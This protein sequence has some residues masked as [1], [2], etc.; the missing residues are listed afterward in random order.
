M[1][2]ILLTGFKGC[3]K[4]TIGNVMAEMLEYGFVD[5]DSML[6]D[7]YKRE[8]GQRLEFREIFHKIGAEAFR[9]LELRAAIEVADMARLS[10]PMVIALGGGALMREET[11]E[12]LRP[13]GEVVYLH[14]SEDQIVQRVRRGGFPAYIKSDH[15]EQELIQTYRERDPIYRRYSDVIV[16][17][18]SQTPAEAAKMAAKLIQKKREQT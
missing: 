4:S 8:N 15:P 12:V 16:E 6:E 11:R 18:D 2:H 3:G 13:I 17:L 5:L 1:C 14:T 7:I 10:S 9:E